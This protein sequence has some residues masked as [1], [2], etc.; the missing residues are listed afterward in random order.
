MGCQVIRIDAAC[1]VDVEACYFELVF[2]KP[3]TCFQYRRVLDGS[4]DDVVLPAPIGKR[5]TFYRQV[6]CL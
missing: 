3:L 2:F 6:I 5:D 4:G 1:L